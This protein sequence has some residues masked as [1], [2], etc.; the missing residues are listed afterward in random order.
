MVVKLIRVETGNEGTFGVL[1]LND[2]A[3]CVTLEPEDLDN[4]DSISCIPTGTYLCKRVVSPKYGDVFEVQDVPNREHILFHAGNRDN[5][6]EGCIL[7]AQYFGK[8]KGDRAVL[9]SGNTLKAFRLELEG[10]M[11]FAL[12]IIEA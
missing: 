2:E 5:N 3:F 9:N 10:H 6:T 1:L 7:L 4:Q 8:L 12:Q 11:S